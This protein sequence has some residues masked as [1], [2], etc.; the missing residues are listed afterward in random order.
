MK[1]WQRIIRFVGF[2]AAISVWSTVVSAEP[3]FKVTAADGGSGDEFGRAVSIDGD[4]A[5]VGAWHIGTDIQNGAAYIYKRASGNTWTE[6]QKLTAPD[7]GRF[8]AS[9]SMATTLS[10]GP[11]TLTQETGRIAARPMCTSGIP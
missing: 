6:I 11:T 8:G 7:G 1:S 3:E 9:V 4:F 10:S 2:V 5:V